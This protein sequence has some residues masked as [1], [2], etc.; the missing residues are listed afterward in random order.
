[1]CNDERFHRDNLVRIGMQSIFDGLD[2]LCDQYLQLDENWAG[3]EP[4]YQ[5]PTTLL[6][7]CSENSPTVDGVDLIHA[8]YDRV[9]Q[10][11]NS[12]GESQAHLPSAENWRFE[13]RLSFRD[14][15]KRP[16]ILLE[17]TIALVTDDDNWANQVPVDSG[18]LGA[19]PHWMDL[20]FRAGDSYAFIELKYESNTP[21]SAACQVLQ[22]GIVYA[23]SRAHA[24]LL[25]LS[26]ETTA[27]L[28][29][30]EIALK[31]LAPSEFYTRY[32]KAPEWLAGF[33]RSLNDG[34]AR[35]CE[36]SSGDWPTLTFGFEAFPADFAWSPEKAQ[37]VAMQKD[38]LWAIHNRV[39]PFQD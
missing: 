13:K 21:L 37:D 39:S 32:G 2:R 8:L 1:M 36:Q 9:V 22:Y 27:L 24:E 28:K 16:E 4:R 29:A 33:E 30:S 5:H 38:V 10:N 6:R 14:D 3:K 12:A 17:R 20:V 7:L 18:L 11:W 15:N 31:V 23:F 25:Q 26:V 35:F 19:R 34:L